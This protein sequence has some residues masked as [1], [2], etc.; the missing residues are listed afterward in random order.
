LAD[1]FLIG[2]VAALAVARLLGQ[3]LALTII[4]LELFIIV[5]AFW[6]RRYRHVEIKAKLVGKI[7]MI[8]QSVGVGLLLL[9]SVVGGGPLLSVA[10]YVLVASVFFSILSL[11]VYR[12]I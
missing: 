10:F 4:A 1:K 12:S 11:I 6:M 8:L 7:K 3:W 2:S 9:F 5:N